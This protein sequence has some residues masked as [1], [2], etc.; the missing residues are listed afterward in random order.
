MDV[1]D[2]DPALRCLADLDFV[3][4]VVVEVESMLIARLRTPIEERE[5]SFSRTPE[6]VLSDDQLGVLFEQVSSFVKALVS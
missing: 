2:L 3:A 1:C 4:D 6:M 5:R